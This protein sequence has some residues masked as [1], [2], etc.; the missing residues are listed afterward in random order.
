M[1]NMVKL[2]AMDSGSGAGMT[3]LVMFEKIVQLDKYL[4]QE[5]VGSGGKFLQGLGIFIDSASGMVVFGV[6]G[7]IAALYFCKTKK[8]RELALFF[9]AG[10]GAVFWELFLKW[11][12]GRPR[13]GALSPTDGF[14][15]PSGH[16]TV[17][18]AVFGAI[19]YLFAPRIKNKNWR[20]IFIG[21]CALFI[22][23]I[24]VSRVYLGVHWFSDVVAGF[25]LGLVWL[26]LVIFGFKRFWR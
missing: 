24:G 11:V 2:L 19:I 10:A 17:S 14:S 26:W 12:F 15:F 1:V 9:A 5:F 13:P 6:I 21:A 20:K 22:L 4:N 16:A 7:L 18:L 8:W 3:R 23:L 25:A